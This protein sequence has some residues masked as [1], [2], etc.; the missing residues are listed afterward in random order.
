V[1]KPTARASERSSRTA[2][3]WSLESQQHFPGGSVRES[4]ADPDR[5][6][7]RS[8]LAYALPAGALSMIDVDP[9]PAANR[10]RF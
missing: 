2:A 8:A 6:L 5:R 4:Q 7:R 10:V 9:G 1:V 3:A